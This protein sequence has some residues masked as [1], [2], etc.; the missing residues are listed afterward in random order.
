MKPVRTAN[1]LGPLT[2]KPQVPMTFPEPVEIPD[3]V[4]TDADKEAMARAEAKR[5]RKQQKHENQP[6]P[7]AAARTG[8]MGY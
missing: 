4:L 5:L 2:N 1:G 7:E 6:N 8:V 3:Y